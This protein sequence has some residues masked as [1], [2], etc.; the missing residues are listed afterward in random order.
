MPRAPADTREDSTTYRYHT[1]LYVQVCMPCVMSCRSH[2]DVCNSAVH[3]LGRGPQPHRDVRR[4]PRV[5][6]LTDNHPPEWS[7][8]EFERGS[9]PVFKVQFLYNLQPP[10]ARRCLFIRGWHSPRLSGKCPALVPLRCL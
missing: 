3:G 8:L 9:Y 1:H 2:G 10:P 7:P 5:R 6:K 4:R